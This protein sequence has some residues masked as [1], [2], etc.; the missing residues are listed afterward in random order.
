[1]KR[2]YYEQSYSDLKLLDLRLAKLYLKKL[3]KHS[4]KKSLRKYY[5]EKLLEEKRDLRFEPEYY[6]DQ[7]KMKEL[8]EEI[9]DIHNKIHAAT[10]TWEKAMEESE[11]K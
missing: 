1:M 10:E 5:K 6:Q 11:N 3:E 8:D 4:A 9:D 2:Y 7:L